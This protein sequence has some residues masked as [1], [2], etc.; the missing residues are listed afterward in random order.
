[1]NLT[2]KELIICHINYRDI[3]NAPTS[4][5]ALESW[6]LTNGDGNEVKEFNNHISQLIADKLIIEK[7]G[8]FTV[9]GKESIIEMQPKKINVSKKL[10]AKGE[11]FI[12]LFSKIPFIKYVGVSGSV[13]AENP[14]TNDNDHVDLDLFVISSQYSLW[15]IFFI[16]RIFT[17]IVRL[18][19]G[20][21]FYCFNYVTEDNFLE[22]H[23]QNFFTATEV[24]NLK[25]VIDKGVYS[26][27]LRKNM[28]AKKYYKNL[29]ISNTIQSYKQKKSN[30]FIRLINYLFFMAFCIFR[31]L[32][33]LNLSYAFEFTSKFDPSKKCNLHRISN[34]NGGYQ[35]KIKER[36]SLLMKQNFKEF[37]SKQLIEFLFPDKSSFQFSTEENVH[38][39][40]IAGYFEKYV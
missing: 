10:V 8:F 19:N 39:L 4:R 37:Y 12:R 3:F 22:V 16:E 32:K 36:F 24:V 6:L 9:L 17:N 27:F 21:H 30:F 38:D 33:K 7:N 28:W 13:A 26:E 40:E 2:L 23:N 1:M 29:A 15:L 18:F 34:P 25:T 14:T 5:K 35:E 31:G 11:K 20:D